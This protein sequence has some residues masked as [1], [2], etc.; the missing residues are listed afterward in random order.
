MFKENR[1]ESVCNGLQCEQDKDR[2]RRCGKHLKHSSGA[3]TW[4]DAGAERV[5]REKEEKEKQS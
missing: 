5:R 1:C 3:C 2:H 4:T